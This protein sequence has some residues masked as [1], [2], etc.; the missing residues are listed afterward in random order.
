MANPDLRYSYIDGRMASDF[1]PYEI[2]EA[3]IDARLVRYQDGTEAWLDRSGLRLAEQHYNNGQETN[4]GS[5]GD[6]GIQ[7]GHT[8][9]RQAGTRQRSK[10]KKPEASNSHC[11][12]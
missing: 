11:A 12:I 5:Q 1:V 2:G 8:A 7:G 3:I 4:Q 10:G 6:E 9:N